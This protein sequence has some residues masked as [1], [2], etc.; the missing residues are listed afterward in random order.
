MKGPSLIGIAAA[1]VLVGICAVCS[2]VIDAVWLLSGRWRSQLAGEAM[3]IVT[4]DRLFVTA[5][6]LVVAVVLVVSWLYQL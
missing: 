3:D 5:A 4:M 6:R 2:L 1:A